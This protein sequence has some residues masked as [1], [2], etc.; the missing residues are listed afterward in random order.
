[1]RSGHMCEGYQK[2]ED[3][4]LPVAR[5]TPRL[6]RPLERDTS[7]SFPDATENNTIRE[8]YLN[9]TSSDP[10]PFRSELSQSSSTACLSEN[11]DICGEPPSASSAGPHNQ[12]LTHM[13]PSL[14]PGHPM[15]Q[16]RTI[17]SIRDILQD[18]LPMSYDS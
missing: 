4:R 10:L 1:M 2:P 5:A 16:K 18:T 6:L 9:T 8:E 3:P 13:H 12:H 14:P 11:Q 15:P 7:V 17:P